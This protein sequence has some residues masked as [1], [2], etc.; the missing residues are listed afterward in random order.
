MGRMGMGSDIGICSFMGRMGMG[1]GIGIGFGMGSGIQPIPL[2]PA[3]SRTIRIEVEVTVADRYLEA[4][5]HEEGR[6]AGHANGFWYLLSGPGEYD[7]FARWNG[8]RG[9]SVSAP[10]RVTVPDPE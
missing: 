9:R 10:V 2:A 5:G 3:E 4:W 8:P 7:V 6:T 1:S